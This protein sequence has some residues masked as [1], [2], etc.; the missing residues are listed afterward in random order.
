MRQTA[1]TATHLATRL[2]GPAPNDD[3]EA[4]ARMRYCDLVVR[5]GQEQWKQIRWALF[6]FPD[7]SDVAPTEDPDAVRV[8][9][10]GRCPYPRI[11]L[12]ELLQAGFD[13]LPDPSS[14]R[15]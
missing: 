4:A 6:V 2:T 10:R 5:H 9:Y 1:H 11:W 15:S 7:I 14:G 3:G 13:A 8:F 12:T